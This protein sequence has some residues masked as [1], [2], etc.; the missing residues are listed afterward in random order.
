MEV[1]VVSQDAI[2]TDWGKL[3]KFL[4]SR[5]PHLTPWRDPK[6][7]LAFHYQAQTLP[8]TILYDAAGKEVWRYTGGHDWASAE[9]AKLIAEG[10]A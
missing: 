10:G 6:N 8:T 1:L 3:Q 9:A 7:D 5:A 2:A 4:W